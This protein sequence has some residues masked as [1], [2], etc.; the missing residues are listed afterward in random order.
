MIQSKVL[1]DSRRRRG[2]PLLVCLGISLISGP[3][4]DAQDKATTG[5]TTTE[6]RRV[7]LQPVLR[8]RENQVRLDPVIRGQQ[9]RPEKTPAPQREDASKPPKVESAPASEASPPSSPASASKKLSVRQPPLPPPLA[10][11][12]RPPKTP[13]MA[14]AS[15]RLSAA[16]SLLDKGEIDEARRYLFDLA[17]EI[18][19]TSEGAQAL[20]MAALALNDI[21][22]TRSELREIV[23]AYP[24]GE[25]SRAAL[26]RMGDLS[27]ILGN[28][29]DSIAAY[30]DFRK[31]AK[32]PKDKRQADIRIA[33]ALLRSERYD[34]SLEALEEINRDYPQLQQTPELLEA[35]AEALMATGQIAEADA[36]FEALERGF[37]NYQSAAKVLLNRGLCA[38]LLGDA[39]TAQRQYT[40][41]AEEYPGSLEAGLAAGRLE[42]LKVPLLAGALD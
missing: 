17:L 1:P 26:A 23:R 25:V 14:R 32:T 3:H 19:G 42:D 5:T 9:P 41:I 28:Y 16:Q 40:L 27:F 12:E 36:R 18:H 15:H 31:L 22:Q 8:P 7:R 29:E 6:T 20:M 34:Q 10:P 4:A 11:G 39:D 38:E 35:H 37:P 24:S 13:S 2:L 21:E 33:L 30:R